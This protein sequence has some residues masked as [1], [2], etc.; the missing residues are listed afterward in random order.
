MSELARKSRRNGH[1]PGPRARRL[2]RIVLVAGGAALLALVAWLVWLDARIT[3]QF[4]GRRWDLPAQ[5]FAEPVE[6]YA[7]LPLGIRDFMELLGA[8]GYREADGSAPRPG[9]WWRQGASVRL[10]TRPFRFADG[11]QPA[12][13][14]QVDFTA[15]GVGR[16]RDAQG[17]DLPLLRMDP[18]RI[19]SIFPAHGEDRI[20]LAPD[21]IPALLEQALIAVEDRRFARHR[22]LDPEGIG[23]AFL[24]NLRA[25]EVRQGGSTLTQQLVKSYFLDSRRT[26]G[27]KLTEAAMA[28]LLEWRYD[29]EEILTA[30]INEVFM[31]Q[32]GPR[33]VHG[34]GLAS[35]F[36]FGKPL[37]ELDATETATLVAIVRGPSYYNPWRHPQR[38]RER[39][40]LVLQILAEQGVLEPALA[41]AAAARELGLRGAAVSGPGYLPAFLGLV[42]RQLRRDYRDEDLDSA[43]LTVLTTLDPLAQRKAQAAVTE[44]VERLR[45]RGDALATVEGAAVVTRPA[46][47]EV[48][49]I[50]GGAHGTFDGFNRALDARRPIGS[51][52]K[53]AV[54][55][56]ALES[57]RFTLASTLDDWPL[58]VTLHDGSA[59]QPTNFDE[60]VHGP[61]SMMRALAESLNLATVHL[62]LEIGL[63]AVTAELGRLTGG[64]RP[65]PFPSLLLGSVEY[66]PIT[67]AEIYGAIAAGGFRAPLRS[68][69][70]VLDPEGA[71]LSRYPLA[72]EP[73]A[74]P[75]AVAQLQRAMQLVFERGTAAGARAR[76]G[77]RRFAGKTGTS[78]DFRDSWFAGFGGDTLAVVWVGRDDNAPTGLTG[79]SG[80]LPIWSELM[81]GLGA[82]EFLPGTAEGL[83]EV[84]LEYATGLR[85]RGDCADTVFVPVPADVELPVK[86]DCA[87]PDAGG[88]EDNP[89]ERGLRWLRRTLGTD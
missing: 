14:A 25:G 63:E 82:G 83:V 71:P 41:E 36:Y 84:E 60:Q 40:D 75:A 42:R 3:A 49:A 85:A 43:G 87:P 32:D 6:L 4:E 38:V 1:R 50:V 33:A 21:E 27:R 19:G 46:T 53:P 23:R 18:M 88:D 8:Q 77:G 16:I 45:Q 69:R 80:A 58:S 13:V 28:I 55:L 65:P 34:F 26:L 11:E 22:G 78:G 37:L 76:L 10:M 72:I 81:A 70:A 31:G 73:V 51:L 66:P 20:V 48:L 56:A 17:R 24:V 86:H 39:R 44:G 2:I 54:Y 5:V 9:F 12:I 30:Y 7:G 62:G 61:V 59:W 29:K 68:V 35:A 74:E 79:A 89:I 64:A 47:G 67:V 57:G 15:A 52:V